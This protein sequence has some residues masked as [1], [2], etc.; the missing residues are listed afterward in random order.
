MKKSGN[1][2]SR[3]G[4]SF[5]IPLVLI[6]FF[7]ALPKNVFATYTAIYASDGND[8]Y[9]FTGCF[10]VSNL[11][12]SC[13]NGIIMFAASVQTNGDITAGGATLVHN[14]VYMGDPNW[15][16]NVT[17]LKTPPTSVTR[18]ELCVGGWGDG[19]WGNMESIVNSQGAY[20]TLRT[21]FLA[22][23]TACPGL[24][25]INDDDEGNYDI[26]SSTTI[27]QMLGSIG[28]KMTQVPYTNQSFWVQLKNNL[29]S[30][31]DIV[32]LQ[33]YQG[34]AG[35]DPGQWDSAYG[36]GFH[37]VPGEET[38]YA[39]QSQFTAWA[40]ADGIT[41]GFF[42]PDWYWCPGTNWPTQIA[43]GIGVNCGLPAVTPY[44][45]VNGGSWQQ[46]NNVTV[47]YAAAVNLGPQDSGE[48]WS[49]AGPDGF[50][51]TAREI[52]NIPLVVGA[53]T[54]VVT[55][56]TSCICNQTSTFTITMQSPPACSATGTFGNTAAGTTGY[57]QAGILNCCASSLS[58]GMT[59]TSISFYLGTG[60]SGSGVVGIY[61]DNGGTPGTLLAQSND[62]G[63]AAGW[64]TATLSPIYLP[65]GSYW[66]TASFSGTA[67]FEFTSD[68]GGMLWENYT[69]SGTLPGTISGSLTGYGWHMSIYAS[70]CLQ[71]TPTPTATVPACTTTSATFGNTAAGTG[72]YNLGG[73]LDCAR[74]A[75]SQSM[76][77]TSMDIYM[78]AGTSG[79]GVLG[80]YSDTGV[81][82]SLLVQSN[83]Q[84]LTTG[85]NY[86]VV[87]PTALPAGTY[88]LSGSFTGTAVFDYSA[89][90]G[91][92]MAFETYAYAGS[93]P[94]AVGS[95]TGYGWLMSIYASGCQQPTVTPTR[96][97]TPM[98]CGNSATAYL[99]SDTTNQVWTNC[100][101]P[102]ATPPA[103]SGGNPWNSAN[104]NSA[105]AS[106]WNPAFVINPLAGG[107]TAPCSIAGSGL[108]PNW[109][110]VI[111]SAS[112][113]NGPCNGNNGQLFYYTKYFIVP[114][115]STVTGATLLITGDDG[116]SG[117]GS[118]P[119]GLY[120]NGNAVAVASL[121]WSSCTTV[122]IP[123]A[124][125]H[126]GNNI[127]A[128]MDENETGGQG[129]AYQLSYT[130]TAF[131][132]TPTK[133]PTPTV[134]NTPT[135][136]FTLT[137]TPTPTATYTLTFSSTPTVTY[138]PTRSFTA[139]PSITSTFSPTLTSTSTVVNTNTSTSTR[140]PLSTLSP[141]A[142]LTGTTQPTSTLTA[143]PTSTK[144]STA[145][146]SS[147]ATGTSTLTSTLTSTVSLTSTQTATGTSTSTHT[148]I[149]P[150][151][152]STSTP[153]FTKTFT[154]TS[155]PTSPATN[156]PTLT[157]TNTPLPTLTFTFTATITL[158]VT[159]TP[160]STNTLT[161]TSTPT[162]SSVC[163]GI[164]AWNG[165][166]V[167]YAVGAVVTYNAE[168]Y[169]CIQ[170]HTSEPNWMPPVVPALWK[171][172][173]PCVTSSGTV[174]L[175][176]AVSYPNPSTTGNTMLYYKIAGTSSGNGTAAQGLTEESG[177]TVDI[178]IYTV[179]GRKVWSR[180]LSGM[181]A[182]SGEHNLAWNGKDEMGVSL[183]NGVY[184]Y[185]VTL[186][187]P[188][189][190]NVIR[191]P[192]LIL[193]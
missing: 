136:T 47:P 124:D 87:P 177:A 193:K 48:A 64:N 146:P 139:T 91:G 151:F 85:W 24:D 169:Q 167:A 103:D 104:Y 92:A 81:P 75:L 1:Q 13:W 123:A 115:G 10:T 189:G 95:T 105:N 143:T 9:G 142:T 43:A 152:T 82:G 141:T 11:K 101:A 178:K 192:L 159:R 73:Q 126:A 138:T 137:S 28:L 16:A 118:E 94:N 74:Y 34:G 100:N 49:W 117:G 37:V 132:C 70:G 66:L 8:G 171:D 71:P 174:S 60:S 157:R 96:S 112:A 120:V 4:F 63:L 116:T 111:P 56:T 99:S 114:A 128:F 122:T 52:D 62:Y 119:F 22:L 134:T 179:A 135:R 31:C 79:N 160:V 175:V 6:L 17:N 184:Y 144:T 156:T 130:E 163:L 58:Q 50:T 78:G 18:Y 164:P 42:W 153:T 51:S 15:G 14:G 147:T 182:A 125:L 3:F 108:T 30:I 35:N 173:G 7:C 149:P 148:P 26:N 2:L 140:T 77:V 84:V 76:T 72:G 68:P 88:W 67:N 166:F 165:G 29:G 69:Y 19:S 89:S 180:T 150:V 188:Q 127:I 158:T 113:G 45:Q 154:V 54:F 65:A 38:N 44:L 23:K 186:K 39:S 110:S 97:P 109:I 187:T 40:S 145:T 36:G 27:G 133:T 83:P 12:T 155:T 131:T 25:A 57:N 106:G 59:V 55:N 121:S 90:T 21:N 190:P 102:S 107:W 172:L 41:G 162:I 61:S 5:Y 33:C 46:T 168:K 161:P 93:L 53:N 86:F 129:I 80:I 176:E 181:E 170:A 191:K 32:Y 98:A 183:A 20:G 185:A